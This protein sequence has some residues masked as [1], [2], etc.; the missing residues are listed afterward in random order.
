M[1]GDLIKLLAVGRVDLEIVAEIDTRKGLAR[2][3]KA[4]RPD[5]VV[6]GIAQNEGDGSVGALLKHLPTAKIIALGP[7]GRMTGYEFCVRR[8]KLSNRSPE[9]LI[10]FIRAP[11]VEVIADCG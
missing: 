9:G 7:N 5:L 6:I 11:S 4:L 3:L 10:S 8:S 1:L 2:R